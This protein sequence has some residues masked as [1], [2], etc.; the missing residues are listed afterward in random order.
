MTTR[1]QILDS[2][3]NTLPNITQENGYNNT[4]AKVS[5]KYISDA[6]LTPNIWIMLGNEKRSADGDD[7]FEYTCTVEAELL[8][9]LSTPKD[10]DDKGLISDK[11]ESLIEDI[12]NFLEIKKDP[13]V[14]AQLHTIEDVKRYGISEIEPV[15]DEESPKTL[16]LIVISITYLKN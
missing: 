2:L 15:M 1:E 4:I 11:V 9:Q 5:K 12:D 7:A 6:K 13:S 16:L 3:L 8:I 10:A 14:C